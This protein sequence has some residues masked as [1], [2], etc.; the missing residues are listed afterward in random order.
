MMEAINYKA[1]VIR[2]QE[3]GSFSR[4]IEEKSTQD[5]P[6]HE[7]LIKVHY[8]A[9]NYKDALSSSGHKGITR[10]FPHVPGVDACGEVVHCKSDKF[11]KGDKVIVT[12]YDFGMNTS[13]GFQEYICVPDSWPVSLPEK[14][15]L[16]ES[17]II[18]TGGFTAALALYKMEQ[19]G[20]H[21]SMGKILV[22]GSTGGVGTMAVN[23]LGLNG[24]EVIAST[25]KSEHHQFLKELGATEII[26]REE[27]S[28]ESGR[29]LLRYKWAG[30]IDTVG[31]NTLATCIKACGR[32]GSIAVCGLVQSPKL[33]TTVYPFILNGV[34]VLG[35]ETAETPRNI[36]VELW[37]RLANEWKPNCLHAVK[38]MITLEQLE[39]R[40]DT[41]LK[42]NSK[43]RTVVKF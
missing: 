18:G 24:Y 36:R 31:D 11:E 43:G 2:E 30:A 32:N 33:Q 8:A 20:Q 40:I 37:R 39:E 25:G 17:M 1:F 7:V 19:N 42:G 22:T 16:E 6:D 27:V 26:S 23:L 35:I 38:D 5:L 13:G 9:L 14:M 3:D 12:S 29:P 21:P 28:D 10:E 34:N 4:Q 41:M 15:S